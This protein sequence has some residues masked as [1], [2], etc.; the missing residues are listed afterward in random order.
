MRIKMISTSHV[1]RIENEK[2][3]LENLE[4]NGAKLFH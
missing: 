2:L 3:S 1:Y 4:Q